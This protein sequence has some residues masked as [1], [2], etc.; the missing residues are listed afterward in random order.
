MLTEANVSSSPALPQKQ[1]LPKEIWKIATTLSDE[2][3]NAAIRKA[4]DLR[5]PLLRRGKPAHKNT[6]PRKNLCGFRISQ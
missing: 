3:Q 2:A 5:E 4:R 6:Y 1:D